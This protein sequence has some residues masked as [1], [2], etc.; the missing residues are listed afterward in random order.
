MPPIKH[1]V[2]ILIHC[3]STEPYSNCEWKYNNCTDTRKAGSWQ[4]WL[5]GVSGPDG[6]IDC[7]SIG[8][9][10]SYDIDYDLC[11]LLPEAHFALWATARY[12]SYLNALKVSLDAVR[13]F[14]DGDYGKMQTSFYTPRDPPS[15]LTLPLNILA[16]I[17]SAITSLAPWKPIFAAAAIPAG[18]STIING[19]LVLDEL[20]QPQ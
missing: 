9:D 7:V 13:S 18:I 14:L 16:G 12:A 3:C 15:K 17:M 4:R 11:K 6:I 8:N 2:L 5:S 19:I 20:R 10:C 1:R